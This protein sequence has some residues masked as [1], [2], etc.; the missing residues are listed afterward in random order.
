MLDAGTRSGF[1]CEE[2][3]RYV[4]SFTFG[5]CPLNVPKIFPMLLQS[6]D[7]SAFQRPCISSCFVKDQLSYTSNSS[8]AKGQNNPDYI[9]FSL[10]YSWP[11]NKI[12][13]NYAG[14][15]THGFF[16][17]NTCTIFH[18]WLGAHRQ[19][20]TVCTDVY[21]L[22]RGLEYPQILVSGGGLEPIPCATTQVWGSQKSSILCVV[23]VPNLCVFKG[24][25]YI[26][27]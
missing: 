7:D 21:L 12:V 22:H 6:L 14:L 8:S 11:S 16:S 25:L 5:I 18:P 3:S 10:D 19:K 24:Q 2:G 27:N 23:S 17:I 26:M 13:L 1:R 9:F 4:F 20:L 15:F